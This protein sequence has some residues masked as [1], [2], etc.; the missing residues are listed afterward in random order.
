MYLKQQEL[1]E[2]SK[3]HFEEGKK[4][5]LEK[6]YKEALKCFNLSLKYAP[7]NK[8]SKY[9]RA[10]CHLDSDNTKKCIQDLNELI[11]TDPTYN[12][13]IYVVLSIAYRRENDLNS[14]LRALTK[15]I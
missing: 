10:I 11:D 1:T 2:S 6:N 3:T 5:L 7:N 12:Q 9:Y 8:D 4:L 13:T 15:G 14:S